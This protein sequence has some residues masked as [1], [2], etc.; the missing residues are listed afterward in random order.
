MIDLLV[1]GVVVA[2]WFAAVLFVVGYG[3]AAPWY[4]S[5]TGR[6]LFFSGLLFLQ[7]TTLAAFTSLFGAD[8]SEFF[9]RPY[10]RLAVWV[11]LLVF[12]IWRNRIFVSAQFRKDYPHGSSERDSH[13]SGRK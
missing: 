13:T 4:R 10:I 1:S 6:Q 2:C 7:I 3:L 8:W 5:E 9:A 12:L 11:Q